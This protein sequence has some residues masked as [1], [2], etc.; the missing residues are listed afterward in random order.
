MPT[1]EQIQQAISRVN[2]QTS[3]IQELLYGALQWPVDGG[4]EKVED[5][6][7]AWTAQE[8]HAEGLDRHVIDGQV[9]QIQ[10]LRQKQ[11]WGIFLLDFKNVGAFIK[12][13]GLTGPLRKV[14]RGL[15]SRRRKANLPMW[16]RENL[17][18]ICT[19]QYQYFRFGYFKAPKETKTA[20]L[21]TFGWG[22][23]TPAR[24]ACEFNLPA[25]AWPENSDDTEAW[26][27]QWLRAFDKE[28]LTKDFFKTFANLYHEVVDDIAKVREL[29]DEAG[30]LAQLLLDRM[31]FLYFI[32]KKGW[33]DQKSDYLYSRFI[34]CW[35]KDSEGHSYYPSVLY[36]LFLSLSNPDTRIDMMGAVPFLNGGLFEETTKLSQAEQISHARLQVK[37]STFRLIFDK[38]LERFNFTVVQLYR[39]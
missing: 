14:L 30:R 17:L 24:T 19:H 23:D 7:F 34:E 22:P 20:P 5:I 38:L 8:L 29:K 18:F 33:L 25:L 27:K 12:G 1:P 6:S 4:I 37:N 11:P 28:K 9:W 16:Q 31:L 10:P 26:Q 32:Q 2:D 39:Y 13:R 21:I 35:D 15:V 3:F 36:P